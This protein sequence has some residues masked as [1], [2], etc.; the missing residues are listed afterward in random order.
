[1]ETNKEVEIEEMLME[2]TGGRANV[3]WTAPGPGLNDDYWVF[4]GFT[5]AAS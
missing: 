5:N 4:S 1:M 2:S 3:G